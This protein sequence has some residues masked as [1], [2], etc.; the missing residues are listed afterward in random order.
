MMKDKIAAVTC[1]KCGKALTD[2]VSIQRGMGP[3]CATTSKAAEYG[4]KT[5][6]LFSPR[7]NF[8]WG[9]DEP[10]VW[11]EDLDAGRSV[12]NDMDDV[13]L[14]LAQELGKNFAGHYIIYRDSRKVW[15]GVTAHIQ[16]A[17]AEG[18]FRHNN[19]NAIVSG[20]NFYSIN[21][22]DYQQ[23]KVALFSK[24]NAGMVKPLLSK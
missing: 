18:T 3:E 8:C 20:V 12:T 22:T 21:E 23:A 6:N 14:D 16:F 4:E 17:E 11:I 19:R 1:A 10:I 13:L 15:D 24:I 2:P 7:S 9:V 5:G